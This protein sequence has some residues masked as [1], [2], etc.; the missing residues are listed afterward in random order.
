MDFKNLKGKIWEPK[1]WDFCQMFVISK[2]TGMNLKIYGKSSLSYGFLI[3]VLSI[4][5]VDFFVE[6]AKMKKMRLQS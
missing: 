5:D 3:F 1:L 2:K 4:S 6:M